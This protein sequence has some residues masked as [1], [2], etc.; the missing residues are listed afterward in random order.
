MGEPES[1]SERRKEGKTVHQHVLII[2]H[3]FKKK[4]FL[5]QIE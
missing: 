5:D 1:N 2:K 3:F 4:S